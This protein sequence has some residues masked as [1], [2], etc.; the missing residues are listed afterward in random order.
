MEPKPIPNYPSEKQY[1]ADPIKQASIED[2]NRA[3]IIGDLRMAEVINDDHPLTARLY[4]WL[5]KLGEGEDIPEMGKQ[6][7]EKCTTEHKVKPTATAVKDTTECKNIGDLFNACK[8]AFNMTPAQVLK[9]LG[10][11]SKEEIADP[12]DAYNQIKEIKNA[13]PQS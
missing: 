1:R 11:S 7:P 5:E 2:Q 9:E 8:G 4:W 13:G 3:K 12:Q 6:I 10:L